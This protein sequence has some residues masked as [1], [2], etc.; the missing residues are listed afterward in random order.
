ME[1]V[2]GNFVNNLVYSKGLELSRFSPKKSSKPQHQLRKKQRAL[3][4][5]IYDQGGKQ[6]EG[7]LEIVEAKKTVEHDTG[8]RKLDAVKAGKSK[9]TTPRKTRKLN[10]EPD[11]LLDSFQHKAQ[12]IPLTVDTVQ[13]LHD[14]MAEEWQNAPPIQVIK[15]SLEEARRLDDPN[16][17]EANSYMKW[18]ATSGHKSQGV[19]LGEGEEEED[20]ES[21]GTDAGDT[22]DEEE[23]SERGGR[24]AGDNETSDSDGEDED[25]KEGQ[26]R[27]APIVLSS[28]EESSQ[29]DGEEDGEGT[30]NQSDEKEGSIAGRE[31]ENDVEEGGMEVNASTDEE[32]RSTSRYGEIAGAG[33][34]Y[35]V[36]QETPANQTGPVERTLTSTTPAV[37]EG[38]APQRQHT[39]A[40]SA[41]QALNPAA[42]IQWMSQFFK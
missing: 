42:E 31:D 30:M 10:P 13:K 29:S 26:G 8:K 20:S 14:M 38:Q 27:Q 3:I 6:Y 28:R 22:E 18:L 36:P 19:T 11:S 39:S 12:E 34:E 35:Q 1:A 5:L 40:W 24:F 15:N 2:Y 33:A 21:G 17:F 16:A 32:A 4:N 23:E 25:E 37:D 41:R 7:D 9:N